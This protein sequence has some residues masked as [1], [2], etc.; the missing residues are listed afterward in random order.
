MLSRLLI[1]LIGLAVSGRAEADLINTA[2]VRYRDPE[3]I[4]RS[5]TSNTV[6]VAVTVAVP[7]PAPVMIGLENFPY[8]LRPDDT[9]TVQL[10]GGPAERL[11][12]VFTPGLAKEAGGTPAPATAQASSGKTVTTFGTSVALNTVGPLNPGPWHVSVTAS[13][14][15]GTSNPAEGD[16]ILV[17]DSLI[18]VRAYPNPW[19]ADRG[20][21]GITFAN[22][23]AGSTVKIFT[24]SGQ[25]VKS[26]S[27]PDGTVLWN[28]TNDAGD[29]VG[30]GLF[31]YLITDGQGGKARG[32]LAII[33]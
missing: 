11:V 15:Q 4:T 25:W 21:S 1:G 32:K 8:H 31:L 17:S 27:A 30:S 19:R 24:I 2:S 29:K 6:I 5:E 18:A 20:G 14:A 22:L 9:L 33:R 23:T 16:F 26:L 12:W 10:A 13:N 3:G 7:G 28:L